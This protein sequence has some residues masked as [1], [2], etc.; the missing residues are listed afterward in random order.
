M[1]GICLYTRESE[2]GESRPG[3][4]L[5]LPHEG[6]RDPPRWSSWLCLAGTL[7]TTT[8]KVQGPPHLAALVPSLWCVL[9][10][11]PALVNCSHRK[12]TSLENQV[13]LTNTDLQSIQKLSRQVPLSVCTGTGKV[14][15]RE[16]SQMTPRFLTCCHCQ[17]LEDLLR[18]RYNR[19]EI[20]GMVLVLLLSSL[21]AIQVAIL[22]RL[23]E[24]RGEARQAWN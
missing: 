17:F 14:K 18:S 16:D 19:T 7:P 2:R 10:M 13:R 1:L 12:L 5:L 9:H 23:L 15:E 8:G 3:C 11:E 20:K 22:R 21:L 24:L 4:L 6:P